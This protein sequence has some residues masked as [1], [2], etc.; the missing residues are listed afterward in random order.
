MIS[1]IILI[2]IA[3]LVLAFIA[4]LWLRHELL[5]SERNIGHLRGI[6]QKDLNKRRDTVPYLLESMRATLEPTDIWRKIVE[7]RAIFH[8]SDSL[9]KEMEFEKEILDFVNTVDIKDVNVL[10]AKKDILD[11]TKLI[12]KEKNEIDLAVSGFNELKIKFPYTVA[13][14]IFGFQAQA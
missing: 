10:E 11:L 3:V 7:Q 14:A 8:A 4:L 9:E 12:E 13:S 6:L 1:D 5:N 2:L